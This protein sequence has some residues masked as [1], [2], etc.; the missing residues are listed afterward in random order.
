MLF[1]VHCN[2]FTCCI[3]RTKDNLRQEKNHWTSKFAYT[4]FD[5]QQTFR[6][7]LPFIRNYTF[8]VPLL[9]LNLSHIQKLFMVSGSLAVV[10]SSHRVMLQFQ[11]SFKVDV[12][13]VCYLI[14]GY[15]Y[16]LDSNSI[17]VLANFLC[18]IF[19]FCQQKLYVNVGINQKCV[20]RFDEA[21][22]NNN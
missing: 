8:F 4:F 13:L 22:I 11:Q 19:N 14:S 6:L 1:L 20:V 9:Y 18:C 17:I 3:A 7:K 16:I 21:Q 2:G 5:R 12:K 15:T 10:L